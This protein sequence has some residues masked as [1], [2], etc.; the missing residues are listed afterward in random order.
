MKI[1]KGDYYFP[2]KKEAY[3]HAVQHGWPTSRII[4]YG[5][6]W[7]IQ[8]RVSGPYVG[9]SMY[10]ENYRDDEMGYTPAVPAW[11]IYES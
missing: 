5:R 2:S 10:S 4:E 3:R 6:G 11:A 8:L 9:V 7:A 1:Y